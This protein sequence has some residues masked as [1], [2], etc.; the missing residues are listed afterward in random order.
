MTPSAYFHVAEL[1]DGIY[2]ISDPVMVH[3]T[4]IVGR[5][6]ALLFDTAYGFGDL[7]QFVAGLT[8]LP[9]VVV[10]SHG[11]VDH[12]GGSYQFS[13]VYL[14]EADWE[15][16]RRHT[17]PDERKHALAFATANP[18]ILPGLQP[19]ELPDSFNEEQFLNGGLPTVLPL[20]ADGF[21]DL[22]ERQIQVIATPGHTR[23]SITLYD[24]ATRSLLSA[25]TV[26]RHVWMFLE[27]STQIKE[28]IDTIRKLREFD[29][30]RMIISH[31]GAA[32]EPAFLDDLLHC[33]ENVSTQASR[34]F[35]AALADR[36]VLMYVEGGEP[37]VSPNFVSIVFEESKL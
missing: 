30:D 26:S 17:G 13:E 4:L 9:L 37:F 5:S 7:K 6:R 27:E 1:A 33:A 29:F 8:D 32:L 15:L 18:P 23:G 25:D 10:N 16:A 34:P 3:C 31:G 36:N 19:L 12:I 11:H 22:G 21:F 20:P 28:Y 14:H 35:Y 24:R 2:H